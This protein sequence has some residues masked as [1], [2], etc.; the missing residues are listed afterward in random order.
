VFMGYLSMTFPI[1][2]VE[3]WGTTFRSTGSLVS[4]SEKLK[5]A[6]MNRVLL[7]SSLPSAPFLYSSR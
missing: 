4:A 7:I 2:N 3:S 5:V 1:F 6:W